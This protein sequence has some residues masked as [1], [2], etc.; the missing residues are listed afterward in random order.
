[1]SRAL[2]DLS[3]DMRPRVVEVLARLTERGIA[4]LIVDTLRTEVEHEAHLKSGI[5]K[6]KFS[7]HL[8][9][10]LRGVR[11]DH[12]DAE[13]ADAIDLCPYGQYALHG[14]DKLQWDPVDPVWKIIAEVGEAEGLISGFRW[15]NPFDPGHLELPRTFWDPLTPCP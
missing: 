7:R 11:P 1:M 13:K 9:R 14:P 3:S 4:V 2:D 5:S 10:K 6:A 8:P 15:R 12:P